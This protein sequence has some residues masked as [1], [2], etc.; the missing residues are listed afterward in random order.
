[1][2]IGELT[3]C[4]NSFKT[5]NRTRLSSSETSS[6]LRLCLATTRE[7]GLSKDAPTPKILKQAL[8]SSIEYGVLCDHV[9]SVSL[10]VISSSETTRIE[11]PEPLT[12]PQN[13]K[14]QLVSKIVN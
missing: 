7:S 9:R 10:L 2:T 11:L 5:S 12:S 14:V 3:T 1:M 6:I 4:L 13:W 8:S